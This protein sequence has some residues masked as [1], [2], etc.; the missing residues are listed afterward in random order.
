MKA[1]LIRAVK[2][3]AQSA[4]AVIGTDAIALYEVDWR[5]VGG[6]AALGFVLSLLTSLAGVPEANN[7]DNIFKVSEERFLDKDGGKGE[8][9]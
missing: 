4:L 2:T 6:A 9:D 1:V 3:A 7:G 5:I 8:D